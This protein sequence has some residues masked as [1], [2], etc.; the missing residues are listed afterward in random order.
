MDNQHK[1]I[2]TYR[3]LSQKEI[4]MMNR[5][6]GRE[7]DLLALVD[8]IRS[9]EFLAVSANPDETLRC[10]AIAE[11]QIQTAMMW[12]VRSVALPARPEPTK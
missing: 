5:C 1:K 12:L 8:E 2:K 10:V 7:G 6:K 9:L 4:D 3:D 11:Q